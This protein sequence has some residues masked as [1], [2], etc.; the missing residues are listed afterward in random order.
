MFFLKNVEVKR[1]KTHNLTLWA[2]I[3]LDHQVRW[4]G[5]LASAGWFR[6]VFLGKSD[7]FRA[8]NLSLMG[9]VPLPSFALFVL[10]SRRI[11]TRT[12]RV[13][14]YD[15]DPLIQRSQGSARR[16]DLRWCFGVLPCVRMCLWTRARYPSYSFTK[17]SL[18]AGTFPSIPV[19]LPSLLLTRILLAVRIDG[20][21]T[22][23]WQ[24]LSLTI[25]VAS[26]GAM[27]H[28][29][30]GISRYE[31]FRRDPRAYFICGLILCAPLLKENPPSFCA[32][33][34]G[35]RLFLS[36]WDFAAEEVRSHRSC[37]VG[38]RRTAVR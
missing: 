9:D 27:I 30:V 15:H 6:T 35:S 14:L 25:N 36:V 21:L 22:L 26:L 11:A 13:A 17:P 1:C 7:F 20:L 16:R 29:P 24:M 12:G 18:F 37:R 34:R 5:V 4:R 32:R 10:P 31:L 8:V 2:A 23:V 33:A 38:R 3:L 28:S 19:H